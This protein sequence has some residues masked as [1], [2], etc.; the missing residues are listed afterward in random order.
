M[1]VQNIWRRILIKKEDDIKDWVRITDKAVIED[2]LLQWQ[3][4]HFTQSVG[5]PFTDSFWTKE[6]A[7]QEVSDSIIAGTYVPPRDL[8]WE[9]KAILDSMK[10]S[11]KIKKEINSLATLEQ[12]QSFYKNAT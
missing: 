8:Q 5:T 6:L 2:M 10:R 4:H 3:V 1:S 12:F 7:K 11:K 9:A